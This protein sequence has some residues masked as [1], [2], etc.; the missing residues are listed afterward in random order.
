MG[1]EFRIVTHLHQPI[2]GHDQ[3]KKTAAVGLAAGIFFNGQASHGA[4]DA[5]TGISGEEAQKVIEIR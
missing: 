1:T 4:V 3:H 5:P 2:V